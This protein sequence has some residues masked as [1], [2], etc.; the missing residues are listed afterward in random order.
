MTVNID[1]L[2]TRIAREHF[3]KLLSWILHLLLK[4]KLNK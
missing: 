2:I 3:A 4:N 1:A